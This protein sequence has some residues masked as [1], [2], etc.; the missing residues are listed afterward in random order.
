M[1]VNPSLTDISSC[2]LRRDFRANC[3][4]VFPR[5]TQSGFVSSFNQTNSVS[6]IE[7]NNWFTRVSKNA[8]QI[9]NKGNTCLFYARYISNPLPVSGSCENSEH[10][11]RVVKLVQQDFLPSP[12]DNQATV[13]VNCD[14]FNGFAL[15]CFVFPDQVMK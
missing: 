2:C 11:Q 6:S 14:T 9:K 3:S 1:P 13:E 4:C 15:R 8:T 12:S 5:K 10:S 7:K